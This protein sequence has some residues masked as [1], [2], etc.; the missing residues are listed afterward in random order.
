MILFVN[1]NRGILF[2][3]LIAEVRRRIIEYVRMV[4]KV[5]TNISRVGRVTVDI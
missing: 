2:L 3:S 5:T 1:N 4:S